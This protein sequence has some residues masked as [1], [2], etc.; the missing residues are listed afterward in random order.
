M[1]KIEH[2]GMGDHLRELGGML[3]GQPHQSPCHLMCNWNKRSLT[4]KLRS[5]EG[6][7]IFWELLAT[8]DI[9]V[10]GFA[11]DACD[12]LGIGYYEQ[13]RVKP[14]IIYCQSNGF[15]VKG[16]YAP[17]ARPREIPPPARHHHVGHVR[18]PNGSASYFTQ[19]WTMC[20]FRRT[21]CRS[22]G[23]PQPKLS[24]T[25][26]ERRLGRGSPELGEMNGGALSGAA[27]VNLT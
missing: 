23:S 1:I 25:S 9:F 6:R 3:G 4:L 21:A 18:V 11:N 26:H 27:F 14:D 24:L 17:Q 20:H 13:V 8:A 5:E 22:L 2:P 15:G 19:E 12:K 10:D 7:S 16:P